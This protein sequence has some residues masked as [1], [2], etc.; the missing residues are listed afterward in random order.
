[1]KKLVLMV[2]L[3]LLAGMV[4]A[5]TKTD[6]RDMLVTSGNF[7]EVGEPLQ[8]NTR[9]LSP[10]DKSGCRYSIVVLQETPTD[11]LAVITRVIYIWVI[12]NDL[13]TERAYF[14]GINPTVATTVSF[15]A[16]LQSYIESHSIVGKIKTH[17]IVGNIEWAIVNRYVAGIDEN[18]VVLQSLWVTRTDGATWVVKIIE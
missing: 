16:A 18:H 11:T 5:A 4:S 9:S 14:V 1:M 2:S 13:S 12:D 15:Y 10:L 17:G 3:L 7:A 8:V 6:L